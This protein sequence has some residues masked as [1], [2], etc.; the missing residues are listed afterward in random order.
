MSLF[1]K[2]KNVFSDTSSN[3]P[4][5]FEKVITDTRDEYLKTST[6]FYDIKVNQL[7]PCKEMVM[8]WTDTKKIDFILYLIEATGSSV[9]KQPPGSSSHTP[10]GQLRYVRTGYINY[11][12]RTKIQLE[13]QDVKKIYEAFS[14]NKAYQHATILTWPVNFFLMRIENLFGKL[15]PSDV[16]M[17]T[18]QS[19]KTEI[20]E[21]KAYDQREKLKLIEKIDA[22]LFRKTNGVDRIKPVSLL[23]DD[24]LKTHSNEQINHFPEEERIHW[25][26]LISLA[27][28]AS[29]A[30]PAKK[31]LDETKT[32]IKEL[33][34]DKFKKTVNDW[35]T[36]VIQYKEKE[37]IN[38]YTSGGRQYENTYYEF[39]TAINLDAIKGFVWM[40][41]HFHDTL[42]LHTIAA[43]AE[44][45]YKKIPEKGPVAPG[46]GNAC[47][48]ALFKSKGLDGIGQLSRLK[49]RI[50]QTSAQNLIEKYLLETAAEKGISIHEIEDLS[51][52][53]FGLIDGRKEFLFDDYKGEIVI[54]GIGKTEIKWIKPDGSLQKTMPVFVKEKHA[55]KLKKL[56]DTAKH[57][58][59]MLSAQRDRIDRMFRADRKLNQEHFR[60]CYLNHGLISYIA[61]K[62]IWN[63]AEGER[64][65][66]AIFIKDQWINSQNEIVYPAENSSV[67]LWHPATEKI[68]Q[69]REWRSFLTFHE[70]Q[71]P[72]KQA[73]REIYLLTEAEI[74]TKSYSNRMAAHLLK[75]HQFNML[76]KTRGWKYSLIGVYDDGRDDGT[77]TLRLPEFNLLASYWVR[78]VDSENAYNETGIWNY[79]ATDQVRFTQ[80]DGDKTIDLIDI[81]PVPF[82][83]TLRDIDLFVGVASVG[84]D[85]AWADSGG[86][87]PAY[88]SYWQAYSFGELSE[89]AKMRKDILTAL[90]PRLKIAKVAEVRDK[91]LIVRGKLRT[92]KIHIGSTNILM[93]P[94]DQYLCI[95]PDSRQKNYMENIFLPFEGDNGLSILLS[96]AF[97]LADDDKITDTTITSQIKKTK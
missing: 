15:E 57:I 40:C 67:S 86:G 47:F 55:A 4:D 2:L 8:L 82:S 24:E 37:K 9:K 52:E 30:K 49:L 43:L 17:N 10:E 80:L 18:L 6:Y 74:N 88:R 12:F 39:L 29:G 16:L 64:T 89:V 45:C 95:V 14:S 65:V 70:I 38:R 81:P 3:R 75:Q 73:F 96:K 11:L 59:Q 56:K 41:S 69:V 61:R 90:I 53:D 84:N 58:E 51:V 68:E 13:E 21:I 78:A 26:K 94:N 44:R 92:Y 1:N 27:Q 79:V 66:S 72:V 63:F 50:K 76:A 34:T 19:L 48:Y 93:E 33:G 28:K 25:Y 85:P 87:L 7:S 71:Q 60:N 22:F 32:L 31:F 46:L 42:T 83:E 62:L 54:T 23:G 97:L 5:E 77:A 35:F 36:F 91:F 20:E